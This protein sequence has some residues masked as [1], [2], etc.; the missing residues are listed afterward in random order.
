MKII[1]RMANNVESSRSVTLAFLGDSVTQ[2]CFEICPNKLGGVDNVYDQQ[3]TYGMSV[4]KILS[5]LFPGVPVNIINAGKSGGK[6]VQG[7][8]RLD[9]DVICHSPDLTVVCFGLND[10]KGRN[11]KGEAES[12]ETYVSALEGIFSKLQEAG[13]ESIFMTPNMMNTQISPHL[14]DPLLVSVAEECA[15]FQNSGVLE[16]HIR[17][18]KEL[19][20]RMNIPVCDCY[21][22]WKKLYE[23]GVN[24]TEL[25]SNKINHPSREMN[26]LFAVDL[27]RTMFAED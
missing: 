4:L 16:A 6:A 20:K 23:S 2:G 17:A 7:L 10:C 14:T 8:M 24:T 19:C 9:R 1:Q 13:I 27:V 3:N 22:I 26:K 18:A 5:Y 15:G 21:A 25:L 12:V 11:C